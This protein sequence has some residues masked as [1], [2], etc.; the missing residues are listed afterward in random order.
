MDKL[1]C[2]YSHIILFPQKRS[3][4][5]QGK[6]IIAKTQCSYFSAKREGSV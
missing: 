1:D 2:K 4:A 6:T 3:F 5:E